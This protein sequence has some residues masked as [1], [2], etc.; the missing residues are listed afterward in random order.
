MAAVDNGAPF[1]CLECSMVCRT[2]S[3]LSIHRRRKHPNEYHRDVEGAVV[4]VKTRWSKEEEYVLAMAKVKILREARNMGQGV[5]VGMNLMLVQVHTKKSVEAIKGHRTVASYR[6]LVDRL[7]SEVIVD[8]GGFQRIQDVFHQEVESDEIGGRDGQ[9]GIQNS[10]N[11][12]VPTVHAL[13]QH[14]LDTMNTCAYTNTSQKLQNMLHFV[15]L[16]VE[17]MRE[18]FGEFGFTNECITSVQSVLDEMSLTMVTY[19]TKK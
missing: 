3:G 4:Y 2:K 19:V 18:G 7:M 15:T 14:L 6:A 8:G 1:R 5:P 10:H 9:F 17:K 11:V 12:C 13:T 16:C